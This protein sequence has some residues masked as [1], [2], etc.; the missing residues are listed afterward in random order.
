VSS[1]NLLNSKK[2]VQKYPVK[3]EVTIYFNPNNPKQS[4]IEPWVHSGVGGIL[5]V[6]IGLIIIGI[7]IFHY[8]DFL[9]RLFEHFK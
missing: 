8:S 6:S 7:I 5:V 1:G 4:V 2:L 3:K 9:I